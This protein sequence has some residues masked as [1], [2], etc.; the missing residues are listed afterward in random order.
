MRTQHP[1]RTVPAAAAALTAVASGGDIWMLDSANYNTGT[2]TI[3]KSASILAVPG[4]VGSL[5]ALNNGPAI[6]I[7]AAGLTIALRN[8]VIGPLAGAAAGATGS[9]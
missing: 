5:V 7:T 8:L 1:D 3:G 2:V 6:S 4:A 9:R